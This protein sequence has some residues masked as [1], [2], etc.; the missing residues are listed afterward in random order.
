M[1]LQHLRPRS[2]FL[3]SIDGHDGTEI[4]EKLVGWCEVVLWGDQPSY[5]LIFILCQL[6]IMCS[7]LSQQH[8]D[9]RYYKKSFAQQCVG[10]RAVKDVGNSR[11]LCRLYAFK[12]FSAPVLPISNVIACLLNS[13]FYI[14]QS[15]IF[16]TRVKIVCCCNSL[17]FLRFKFSECSFTF[18]FILALQQSTN[19]V[20][21]QN[22]FPNKA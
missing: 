5:L 20:L 9:S 7:T 12:F 3:S 21:H 4:V 19:L 15:V 16:S 1:F 11:N 22:I 14:F 2:E 18:K 10:H 13:S 8:D 17:S 6:I